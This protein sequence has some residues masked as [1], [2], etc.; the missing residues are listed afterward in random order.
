MVMETDLPR[1]SKK[2][3]DSVRH[4]YLLQVILHGT[5]VVTP[6]VL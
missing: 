4:I 2:T 1:S 6:L 3:R 5:S